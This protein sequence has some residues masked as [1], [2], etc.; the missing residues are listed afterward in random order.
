[1]CESTHACTPTYRFL[2]T[3]ICLPGLTSWDTPF[4]S[5][6]STARFWFV[7]AYRISMFQGTFGWRRYVT[8]TQTTI[9]TII[10]LEKKKRKQTVISLMTLFKI[11]ILQFGGGGGREGF[12][13]YSDNSNHPQL[14]TVN[15]ILERKYERNWGICCIFFWGLNQ[16]WVYLFVLYLYPT[17]IKCIL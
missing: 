6:S 3:W 5:L 11:N 16:I 1:M 17:M 14:K 9:T 10:S 8:I 13:S 4:L 15:L 7:F 12:D 2:K